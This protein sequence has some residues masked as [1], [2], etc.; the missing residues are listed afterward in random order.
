MVTD[1]KTIKKLKKAGGTA[2][3]YFPDIGYSSCVVKRYDG[4]LTVHDL[5]GE[6]EPLDFTQWISGNSIKPLEELD[7]ESLMVHTSIESQMFV[8]FADP[9]SNDDR[10]REALK[11]LEQ[12]APRYQ[13][14]FRM[15]VADDRRWG[16]RKGAM[17][18]TWDDTPAMA[19]NTLDRRSLVY[20][21]DGPIDKEALTKWFDGMLKGDATVV[22]GLAKNKEKKPV[23]DVDFEKIALTHTS[24]LQSLHHFY[25]E[26]VDDETSDAVVL[27]YTSEFIND[28][29]RGVG[30]VFNAFARFIDSVLDASD[31]IKLAALDVNRVDYPEILEFVSPERLPVIYILPAF[32]KDRHPIQRFVGDMSLQNLYEFLEKHGGQKKWMHEK[33]KG[34]LGTSNATGLLSQFKDTLL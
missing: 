20:P 7:E 10:T 19:F 26:M 30:K 3:S 12:L 33:V 25:N 29:Q 11:V 14:Y 2:A 6:S 15:Y 32:G 13:Q 34:L 5:S 31:K 16:S 4:A 24:V 8:V 22:E 21:K 28:K 9:N 1:A 27:L 23:V 17:G 18:I